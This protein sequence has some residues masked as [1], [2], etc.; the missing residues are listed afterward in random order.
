MKLSDGGPPDA[1][2][3]FID[4]TGADVELLCEIDDAFSGKGTGSDLSHQCRVDP[5][6]GVVVSA[7]V[8]KAGFPLF[9]SVI[10][11]C[12]PFQI[13][14]SVVGFDAVDMVDREA[15]GIAVNEGPRN[16]TVR[17]KSSTFL[18]YS[19][20]S[21]VITGVKDIAGKNASRLS[22]LHCRVSPSI[23]PCISH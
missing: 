18:V 3:N 14:R 1:F 8:G 13:S 7:Q 20:L 23:R 15:F 21:A 17:Q 19:H 9:H 6:A 11:Q 22:G 2:T 4:Q 10:S 12:H 16:K 5:L